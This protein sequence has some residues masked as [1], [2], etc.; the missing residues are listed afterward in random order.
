MRPIYEDYNY[1]TTVWSP[2][3]GGLLT[4]KY[5]DG[6]KH[7]GTR[8]GTT[9]TSAFTDMIVNG[10]WTM[11]WGDETKTE[12]LKKKLQAMAALAE[13]LEVT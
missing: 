10:A 11:W 2:L 6:V 4:G 12:A 3:A 1:G 13:E 7:E 9:Q 5:N 8:Y